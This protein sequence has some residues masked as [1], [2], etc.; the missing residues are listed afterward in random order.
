[1]LFLISLTF[2]VTLA[3][4]KIPHELQRLNYGVVFEPLD[5]IHL[6]TEHWMHTFAIQLPKGLNVLDIAGCN[7]DQN[8]CKIV[9]DVLLEI[10]QI[11]QDTQH[12]MNNTINSIISLIPERNVTKRQSRRRRSLLP[13]I[14]RISKSLFGTAT[15]DDVQ[16]LANHV[17]ALNR[18]TRTMAHSMQQHD[19]NLASYM[20]TMDNRVANIVKGIK[21]NELAIEHIQTQLF[22]SFNN[23]EQTFS[24]MN[25]LIAKQIEKSRALEKSFSEL[26]KGTYDLV[27]GKLSP[28]LIP[29]SVMQKTIEDIH[30]TLQKKFN[31][32]HLVYNHPDEI[33]KHCQSLHTRQGLTYISVKFPISP[34]RQPLSLYK[35][36]SFPVPVNSSSDHATQLLDLPTL[37]A[38]SND[39]QYYVTLNMADYSKC[40]S[41]RITLCKLR[42]TLTP[43]ISPSCISAL[44]KGD[45]P[46][47]KKQCNFRFL[48]NSLSDLE[49]GILQLSHTSVLVYNTPAMEFD[50]KRSKTMKKGCNFCI[51]EIPCGCA[52][53]T[54]KLYL[55][56]RLSSCHKNTT[57]TL[58]PVN[59]AVLQQFFNDTDLQNI[60]SNSLFENPLSVNVPQFQIYKHSIQNIIADDRKSH[61][62][63]EKMAK[64]A[65]N[66]AMIFQSLTDPL[67]SGEIQI[68][69]NWPETDDIL[70]YCTSAIAGFCLVA[71][72]LVIL[73]LRKLMIIVSVLK[74]SS[75]Q[76]V[77]AST[78]PS[79][80][81]KNPSTT[82]EPSPYFW[83]NLDVTLDHYILAFCIVTTVLVILM[84]MKN[85]T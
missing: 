1:M 31:G 38:I 43:M 63:L 23:L 45:K 62:S 24:A 15:S 50:C 73:K 82:P 13:F 2:C 83:N 14:G 77:H 56:P 19:N 8:K 72:I 44:F 76:Q 68:D 46:Q 58:H 35:I 37:F 39:L 74:S 57:S 25:V 40:E 51:I 12:I 41:N 10:N 70:L 11:R 59:L 7:L 17:N 22:E 47:I 65:K 26:L 20:H 18:L 66:D 33:Y 49:S 6:A 32:H 71:L 61:L 52:I 78:I 60:E 5:Q 48:L 16:M 84:L 34:F 30:D 3:S 80:V 85:V 27:E 42:K 4:G 28:Y 36:L 21:E 67:L 55:P 54:T 9:N 75:I 53:T 29:V 64:S 81:Y 79:F 69:S